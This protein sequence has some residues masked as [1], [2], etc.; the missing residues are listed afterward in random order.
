MTHFELKL[1]WLLFINYYKISDYI[2]KWYHTKCS[3]EF[4]KSIYVIV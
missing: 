3:V 4:I 1:V 2:D